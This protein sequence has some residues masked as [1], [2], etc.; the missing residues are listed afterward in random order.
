MV[1]GKIV[2]PNVSTCLGRVI[3]FFV[4]SNDFSDAAVEAVTIGDTLCYPHRGVRLYIR[5]R[6]RQMVARALKKMG[7]LE[8]ELPYGP[9]Q[10]VDY[11]DS[12]LEAMSNDD[13]Y[14][15]FLLRME[16][17]V[18]GLMGKEG[19]EL[20]ALMGRTEGPIFVQRCALGDEAGG[21]RKTSSISRAWRRSAR[22]LTDVLR[23]HNLVDTKMYKR[24]LMTYSHPP[25]DEFKAT[26]QQMESYTKFKVWQDTITGGYAGEPVVG[27]CLA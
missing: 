12:D 19:K 4:V 22:W 10:K 1:K 6:P 27:F 23:S 15:L 11:D 2:A 14:K 25:P 8:A 16:A 3:D 18:G 26:P 9:A 13:K 7:A 20:E 21:A 5:A 24:K 17:E